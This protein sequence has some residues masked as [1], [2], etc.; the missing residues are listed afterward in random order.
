MHSFLRR[1]APWSAVWLWAA[2][3]TPGSHAQPKPEKLPYIETHVHLKGD[4][5]EKG[6]VAWDFEAAARGYPGNDGTAN[7]ALPHSATA[8][9]PR[10]LPSN[11]ISLE[12]QKGCAS[13]PPWPP[14]PG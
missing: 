5:R 13:G 9:C 2:W 12:W 8:V 1:M 3:L 14:R 7:R 11:E 10:Q 4:Y 6:K